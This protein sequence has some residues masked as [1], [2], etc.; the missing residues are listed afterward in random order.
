MKIIRFN[1]LAAA[2]EVEK[3][4]KSTLSLKAERA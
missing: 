4:T 1:K 2:E 3:M